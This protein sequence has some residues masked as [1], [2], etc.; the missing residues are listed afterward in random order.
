MKQETFLKHDIARCGAR[1]RHCGRLAWYS[2]YGQTAQSWG[3]DAKFC[4][5]CDVWLEGT[6]GCTDDAPCCYCN[7]RPARPSLVQLEENVLSWPREPGETDVDPDDD[8]GGSPPE[9]PLPVWPLPAREGQRGAAVVGLPFGDQQRR[10]C[11]G[12]EIVH[13]A[14]EQDERQSR[15]RVVATDVEVTLEGVEGAAIATDGT[16]AW[17]SAAESDVTVV[18]ASNRVGNCRLKFDGTRVWLEA[19]AKGRQP[20]GVLRDDEVVTFRGG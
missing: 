7:F 13:G 15:L 2:Y 4:K 3:W 5:A 1:C 10:V 12:L 17:V 14:D 9:P 6:C 20:R 18:L 19:Q 11:V 8:G 16:D